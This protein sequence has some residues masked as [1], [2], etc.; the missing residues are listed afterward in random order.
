MVEMQN[1]KG[2]V[3][4]ISIRYPRDK[5]ETKLRSV[6]TTHTQIQILGY[7][8]VISISITHRF[9]KYTQYAQYMLQC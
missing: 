7:S 9:S 2:H 5:T 3:F 4:H 6:C 1:H 8:P